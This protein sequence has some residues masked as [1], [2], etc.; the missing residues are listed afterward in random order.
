MA[1]GIPWLPVFTGIGI[2]G[3]LLALT[4]SFLAWREARF[5]PY[6][7]LRRSAIRRARQWFWIALGLALGTGILNSFARTGFPLPLEIP[8]PGWLSPP[9]TATPSP[10]PS[11]TATPLIEISPTPAAMPRWTPSP[12]PQP[13]PSPSPTA[14]PYPP[15]L[16]TPI[17]QA[18]P[19][20]PSARFFDLA[21]TD[22]CDERG[23]PIQIPTPPPTTFPAGTER[24]CGRFR[25]ENMPVGAAWTVAW[26]REGE[27]E[28]SSTLLWDGHPNQPGYVYNTRPAGFPPGRWEIRLYIEDR[29]Q[30]R[31]A[32][33]VR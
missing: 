8:P 18:V 26:Y 27:L 7:I 19:A 17:P 21:L 10:I 13:S 29:L 1:S 15:T 24:I 9:L 28:D 5:A 3:V 2:A 4:L 20:P 30:I 32:F 23:R 14:L 6:L 22:A 31:L 11:P 25:V 16:L 12:T 33:E